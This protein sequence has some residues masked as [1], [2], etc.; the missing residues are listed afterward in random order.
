LKLPTDPPGIPKLLSGLEADRTAVVLEHL[1]EPTVKGRYFHWDELRRRKPPDD[2]TSEEWWLTLKLARGLGRRQLPFDDTSGRPFSYVLTDKALSMLHR[3]DRL[4]SGRIEV[5]EAI[6]NEATKDRYLV[7]SLMEEA[8]GSSLLEGAATTRNEAK[9]LLQSGRAPRTIAERM[10]VNNY[11]TMQHIRQD[12]DV[13]LSIDT[14]LEIHRRVTEDTLDDPNDAGRIQEPDEN[15]VDVGDPIDP[16]VV[17]HQPPPAEELPHLL[18]GLSGF[19]NDVESEP[20]IHP[21]VRAVA[22]HF[23]MSYI[24]PFIDGNGRTARALF[25]RSMLRQG[26]WLAEFLSI[27]RLLYQAPVQYARSFLYTETDEADFTYFLLHQLTVICRAIDELFEYLE[28]KVSEVRRVERALRSVP[29]LNHRQLA[30]LSHAIRNPDTAYTFE[31]HRNS[32]NVVYQT[33]RADLLDLEALG[34]LERHQVGRQY[35]FYAAAGLPE[36]ILGS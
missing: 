11:L 14:I 16:A 28:K 6:T 35:R 22:L 30:L 4:A 18:H 7:S 17:F 26:Y 5:P 8:I 23:Y 1:A 34:F 3:I 13:P 32:H 2:L 21:V 9:E 25:Y 29:G 27:S 15:R 33:A 24:H 31:S 12:L 19:A 20:F 36:R 10:V